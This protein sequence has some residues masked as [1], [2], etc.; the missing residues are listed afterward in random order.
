MFIKTA[1]VLILVGLSYER[2]ALAYLT[3]RH[4]QGR[5]THLKDA[6]ERRRKGTDRKN[7]K[8]D[9]IW[10]RLTDKELKKVNG[11]TEKKR[12]RRRMDDKKTDLDSTFF[13]MFIVL[14]HS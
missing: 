2:F 6:C 10:K 4:L 3:F 1:S 14:S 9:E 11:R 13:S 7:D 12:R 8:E 5:F